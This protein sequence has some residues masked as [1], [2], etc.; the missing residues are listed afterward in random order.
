M[1]WYFLHESSISSAIHDL[2]MFY[3]ELYVRNHL[4]EAV[5]RGLNLRPIGDIVLDPVDEGRDGNAARVCRR[6][7]AA[8]RISYH[9]LRKYIFIEGFAAYLPGFSDDAILKLSQMRD[10]RAP[11]RTPRFGA[12]WSLRRLQRSSE[13]SPGSPTRRSSWLIS[14]PP[15]PAPKSRA[16]IKAELATPVQVRSR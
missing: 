12:K 7:F 3:N 10:T 13:L 5:H 9:V 15:R 1:N 2:C 6:I 8:M 4:L 11:D 14:A 16:W